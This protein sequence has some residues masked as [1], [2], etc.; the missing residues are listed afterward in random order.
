MIKRNRR[1]LLLATLFA[2][3][4]S[5]SAPL[6]ADS[7]RS[8]RN[9]GSE[10]MV[11]VATLWS[12][13]YQAMVP[14]S[15]N[16]VVEVYGGGSGN[17]IAALINGH[18][19][20]ANTSRAM[21]KREVRLASRRLRKDPQGHI[22]G[23]DGLAVVV[24]PENPVNQ[25]SFETLNKIYRKRGSMLSW[26]EMGIEVPNCP[27][28]RI[29]AVSRKINTGTYAFFRQQ[30]LGK[31]GLMR[32][33][34][35]YLRTREEVV[36]S[37]ANDPCAI[38]YISISKLSDRIKPVCLVQELQP[39]KQPSSQRQKEAQSGESLL[40][41]SCIA[42]AGDGPRV[43]SDYPMLRPLYM[44]TLGDPDPQV[45]AYIK[46]VQ[47]ENGQRMIESHGFIPIGQGADKPAEE[48]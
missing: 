25:L 22:V 29:A 13:A 24:H 8:I 4:M 14:E 9:K 46:W 7:P 23:W 16:A 47:G 31:R 41:K 5:L 43:A 17:G 33:D 11:D 44:Y 27:K 48:K 3:G 39:V 6:L 15:R 38:G 40:I 19:D 1:P 21:K 28:Q 37:V 36:D 45:L 26:S 18:V 30:V 10:T 12:R 35:D 2:V 34:I 20:I 32:R 42:P